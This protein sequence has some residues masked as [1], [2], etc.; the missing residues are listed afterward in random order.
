MDINKIN[1]CLE[2]GKRAHIL[3]RPYF[4]Y[5]IKILESNN[6]PY[7]ADY[8]TLLGAIRHGQEIYW[9]DDYDIFIQEKFIP[10]LRQM[11]YDGISIVTNPDDLF[12]KKNYELLSLYKCNSPSKD[13][14]KDFYIGIY[15]KM[16][17]GNF[18]QVFYYHHDNRY[19]NKL[20]DIFTEKTNKDMNLADTTLLDRIPFGDSTISTI[21]NPET[22]LKKIYGD[23]CFDEYHICNH[24]MDRYYDINH[25]DKY[26]I[27]TKEEFDKVFGKLKW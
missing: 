18:I 23:K 7:S 19:V 11:T 20:T 14:H 1:E 12:I 3:I 9:D 4:Y 5:F 22:Y 16:I 21:S 27:I 24:Q 26:I 2:H 8:G 17:N 10:E 15:Q 13:F 25:I 6:I